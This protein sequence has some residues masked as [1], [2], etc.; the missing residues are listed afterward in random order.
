MGLMKFSYKNRKAISFHCLYNKCKGPSN[1]VFKRVVAPC[2][3][4]FD[5][6][7]QGLNANCHENLTAIIL[8]HSIGLQVHL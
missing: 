3:C 1:I 6:S 4:G 7:K 8:K 5:L 2:P